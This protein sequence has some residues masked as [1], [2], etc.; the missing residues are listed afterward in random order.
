MSLPFGL[1]ASH[2][3]GPHQSAS[4]HR[5]IKSHQTLQLRPSI[6]ICESERKAA[7]NFVETY[8]ICPG[9]S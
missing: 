6:P 8:L 9:S 3:M 1:A 7:Q 4:I 2:K 5:S